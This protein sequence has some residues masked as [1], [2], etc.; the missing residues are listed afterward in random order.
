LKHQAQALLGVDD[1]FEGG[2]FEGSSYFC[3]SLL[4]CL[5][6]ANMKAECVKLW[7][8]FTRINHE[9]VVP[10]E[11]WCYGLFRTGDGAENQ[12]KIYPST[13]NWAELLRE[14]AQDSAAADIPEA[15]KADPTLLLLFTIVFPFRASFSAVKF[16]HREFDKTWSL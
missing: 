2:S 5:I 11:P 13:G 6:R 1:P 3:E 14:A 7:P 15:L 4:T 8:D 9:R 16:L 10:D 12:T